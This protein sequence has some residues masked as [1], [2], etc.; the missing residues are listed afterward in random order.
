MKELDWKNLSFGYRPTDYNVRC[1]YRDGKWGEIEVCS[2]EQRTDIECSTTLV[3]G[4]P[5]LVEANHLLDHLCKQ[6]CAYLR[7]HDATTG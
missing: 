7:H 2:D 6:L 1:Y 5:L 4:N 3:G